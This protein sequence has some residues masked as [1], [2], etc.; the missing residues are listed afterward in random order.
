MTAV[1][2]TQ[3]PFPFHVSFHQDVY[4]VCRL[5][6]PPMQKVTEWEGLCCFPGQLRV[7]VCTCLFL[8]SERGSVY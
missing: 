8:N 7:D 5:H 3:I 4:F 2:S 1:A 6:H